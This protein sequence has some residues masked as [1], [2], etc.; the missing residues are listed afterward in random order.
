MNNDKINKGRAVLKMKVRSIKHLEDSE[1]DL[2]KIPL[3]VLH[4]IALQQIGEQEAYIEELESKIETMIVQQETTIME[5]VKSIE[6]IR[7]EEVIIDVW[8]R[9]SLLQRKNA[10]LN[11]KLNDLSREYA[12]ILSL[13]ERLRKESS[14]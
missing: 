5:C 11:K 7:R 2:M 13:N 6:D 8:K 1:N 14:S 12:Y 4:R 3:E 9:V 10:K